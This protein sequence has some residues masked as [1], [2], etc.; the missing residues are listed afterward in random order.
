[1]AGHGYSLVDVHAAHKSVSNWMASL[2]HCLVGIQAA[3]SDNCLQLAGW[4]WTFHCWYSSDVPLQLCLQLDGWSWTFSWR[5]T[6][7]PGWRYFNAECIQD[8]DAIALDRWKL[9]S[10]GLGQTYLAWQI[11]IQQPGLISPCQ[12]WW[13]WCC[14][15]H[16]RTSWW[17]Q[18]Y[19]TC[20]KQ[21]SHLYLHSDKVILLLNAD[22]L[23]R[24]RW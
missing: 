2:R 19:W 4:S 16:N 15:G 18:R 21:F 10:L 17:R 12:K 1:M 23:S 14:I 9:K 13:R 22:D 11:L 5:L 8:W 20:N 7:S 3:H 24:R 6:R